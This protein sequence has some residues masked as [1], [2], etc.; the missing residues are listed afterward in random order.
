[1]LTNDLVFV[2]GCN[3]RAVL[4]VNH[5]QCQEAVLTTLSTEIP[6]NKT[7]HLCSWKKEA[8]LIHYQLAKNLSRCEILS[9]E[10]FYLFNGSWTLF[11]PDEQVLSKL[12]VEIRPDTFFEGV[13][14]LFLKV[15]A[16]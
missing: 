16:E 1:V 5:F 9:D 11:P 10:S 12:K 7:L 4:G 15:S 8:G 2:L 6:G 13:N 3:H 14:K